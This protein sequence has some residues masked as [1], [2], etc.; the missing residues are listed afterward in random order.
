M[1]TDHRSRSL[2]EGAAVFEREKSVDLSPSNDNDFARSLER[3][4][5][6]AVGKAVREHL[7]AGRPVAI[8]LNGEVRRVRRAMAGEVADDMIEGFAVVIEPWPEA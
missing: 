2:S 8:A 3:S 5:R 1:S 6:L 4:A 7:A